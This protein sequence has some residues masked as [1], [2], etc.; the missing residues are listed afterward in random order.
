MYCKMTH[1][2]VLVCPD[3]VITNWVVFQGNLEQ[4]RFRCRISLFLVFSLVFSFFLRHKWIPK[5]S[6]V[7]THKFKSTIQHPR[8]EKPS[9]QGTSARGRS[10]LVVD[11]NIS[12]NP[13]SSS[14]KSSYSHRLLITITLSLKE[15]HK[16]FSRFPH[17]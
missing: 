10:Y 14:S 4:S 7:I 5:I 6:A 9:C 11:Y 16:V 2:S 17:H 8:T 1:F 12:N 13:L 3:I 15:V